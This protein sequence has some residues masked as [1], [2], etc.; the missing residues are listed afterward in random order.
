MSEM[1]LS[2]ERFVIIGRGRLIADVSASELT[3]GTRRG[4][5]VRTP[6]ATQLRDL[7]AG[8]GVS[9]TSAE[10]DVLDIDGVDSEDAGRVARDHGIAVY[11]LVPRAATLEDAFL[12]LT[13]D[14]VEYRADVAS[15]LTGTER[16]Q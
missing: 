7:L 6:Q 11:E 16:S 14:E 12:E 10:A 2:A 9:I 1:A 5:R 8:P 3:R 13:R 15:A 4:V